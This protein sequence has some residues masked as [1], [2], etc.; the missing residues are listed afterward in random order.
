[1][2]IRQSNDSTPRKVRSLLVLSYYSVASNFDGK[3]ALFFL[4]EEDD[5]KDDKQ[6]VSRK[7]SVLLIRECR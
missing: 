6:Q 1:M 3:M 5:N 4:E 2:V 7:V